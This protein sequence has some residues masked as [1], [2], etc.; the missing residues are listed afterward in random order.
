VPKRATV[1]VAALLILTVAYLSLKQ[2]G[3]I[4]RQFRDGFNSKQVTPLTHVGQSF[5]VPVELNRRGIYI[6]SAGIIVDEVSSKQKNYSVSGTFKFEERLCRSNEIL[7]HAVL[8]TTVQP[9]MVSTKG[10]GRFGITVKAPLFDHDA[11]I[12]PASS[13]SLLRF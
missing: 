8:E 2:S 5:V 4:G 11:K 9:G 1:F 10:I 12:C 6:Y 7:G 13:T 3:V